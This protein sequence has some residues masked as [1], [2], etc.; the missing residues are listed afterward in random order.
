MTASVDQICFPCE[1]CVSRCVA[2]LENGAEAI[3]AHRKQRIKNR[4]RKDRAKIGV[5]VGMFINNI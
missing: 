2:D 1:I 5:V 4:T 3:Q